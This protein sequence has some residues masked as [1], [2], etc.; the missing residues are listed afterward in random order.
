MNTHSSAA[1]TCI[2]SATFALTQAGCPTPSP[3]EPGT[4]AALERLAEVI[5]A[6]TV[7]LAS[8]RPAQPARRTGT[9][10]PASLRRTIW[11][12]NPENPASPPA[13]R[14]LDSMWLLQAA[15]GTW[16]GRPADL[17][18]HDVSCMG[19]PYCVVWMQEDGRMGPTLFFA[20]DGDILYTAECFLWDETVSGRGLPAVEELEALTGRVVTFRGLYPPAVCTREANPPSWIRATMVP[21][22]A[23]VPVSP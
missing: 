15:D 23:D 13:M 12:A 17:S 1:I 7:L 21:P 5:E 9:D 18:N 2:V 20:M 6:Q 22:G 16:N 11:V 8:T 19:G 3:D 14:F 4:G 10:D